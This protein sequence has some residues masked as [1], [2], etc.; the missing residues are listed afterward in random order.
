M[1]KSLHRECEYY[2]F[3]IGVLW[4]CAGNDRLDVLPLGGGHPRLR[5]LLRGGT[6]IDSL[7]DHRRALLPGTPAQCHG[8]RGAGQLDG[9]LCGRHRIPQH[10]GK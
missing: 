8:H 5:R 7:D 3:C 1:R 10:E 9:Q 2:A 6:R 4:L